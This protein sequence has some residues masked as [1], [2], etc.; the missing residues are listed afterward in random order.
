[1][2]GFAVRGACLHTPAPDRVEAW[3]DALIEVHAGTIVAVHPDAQAA[4]A[5]TYQA[6]GS[7]LHL[8]PRQMLLPGLVDL[9]IHAPQFPNL[10]TALDLPLEQWL[11]DYTFPLEARFADT[12]YAAGVYEDLVATLLANGTTTA[13]YFGTTHLPATQKLSQI[14]LRR[15]QRAYVGRV[16]MDHPDTCPPFYRDESTAT[17]AAQTR[18]SI[19]GIRALPGNTGLVRPIV[20][21]R[22]IPAC[23][24]ELLQ[25]LGALAAETDCHVQTH[26]SESDWEHGHV[27]A[28][29]GCSDTEALRRFGLLLPHGVLAHGN[30]LGDADFGLIRAAGAGVAHCPLS[31]AYFAGAAFPLRAALEKSVRVGLGT[32]VAGGAHPSLLDSVRMAVTTSRMLETGVDP[33]VPAEARGRPASRIGTSEAFWLATV[34]GADVLGQQTGL[35]RPGYAFD[36]LLLDPANPDSNL[37]LNPAEPAAR[38]LER[39][40]HTAGRPDIAAVW[41]NGRKVHAR[42]G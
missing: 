32:D 6:S 37:R 35:F 15:G 31:N 8:A 21:P 34:G 10:G 33:A 5:A 36:A 14:C 22:F 16:A 19:A 39:I 27:L 2:K 24:D 12:A 41:V 38:R 26:C 17:A 1:M 13:V 23:T 9:H 3:P 40:V 11:Q 25:A 42:A 18:A 30:F 20:T 4:M 28:R 7:L 29:C